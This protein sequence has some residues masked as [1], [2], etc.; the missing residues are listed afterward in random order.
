MDRIFRHPAR[1]FLTAAFCWFAFGA[2]PC[3]AQGSL[4]SSTDISIG[5]SY[6]VHSATL[7][8][9]R[10]I[11]V[12]LPRGYERSDRRY[13]VIYVLDAESHFALASSVADFLAANNRIPEMIVVSIPN[14]HRN[15]DLTPESS[16]PEEKTGHGQSQG[17]IT[18]GAD[19]FLKFLADE[20]TPWVDSRL[21]TENFRILVGHS[22][23]GLFSWHTLVNHP[24]AFQAHITV[25]PAL[26]WDHGRLASPSQTEA[27]RK[28]AQ[29]VGRHFMYLTWGDNEP[30]IAPR[31][32]ELVSW[33]QVN[34]P[35]ALQW[36]HRYY[37][38]ETHRTNPHPSLYDGLEWLF[39]GWRMPGQ[40]GYWRAPPQ[41]GQDFTL[42]QVRAH[43]AALSE[44]YGYAIRPSSESI[45]R[46]AYYLL[47]HKQY[48][49][50][51]T[52]LKQNE[53]NYSDEFD[54]SSALG[55]AFENAGRWN[56]AAEAY[57]RALKLAI[58]EGPPYT[59]DADRFRIA[60]A[61]NREMASKK[62]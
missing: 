35:T 16:D 55:S 17:E 43:Y 51:I 12:H 33:L 61:K 37:P 8:E 3:L 18:G 45:Q 42:A 60:V 6:V 27:A 31:V 14:T 47:A 5:K 38:G 26:Q 20:L 30:K 54:S 59:D 57:E 24:D 32:Q 34:P 62:P 28:L 2:P 11:F 49:D 50:A 10:Q 52:L 9:D 48:D 53:R 19:D 1:V 40:E 29:M 23:G 44:K 15:R 21:R 7:G 13:P 25:S 41:R 4:E 39:A 46:V 56:E 36:T 58:A 22:L